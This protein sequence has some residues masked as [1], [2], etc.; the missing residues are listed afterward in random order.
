M[1]KKQEESKS[2]ADT[3]AAFG[4]FVYN[5][6]DGTV[7]GRGA[8]SWGR[9]GVFYLFYYAFLAGLFALSINLCMSLMDDDQPFYQTRLQ[10]PGVTIQ[11]KLPSNIELTS[12][13][14]YKKSD[15]KGYGKYVKHLDTFLEPYD[16]SQFGECGE[17]GYGY[18]EGKPCIF[19]KVNRI[20]GWEPYPFLNLKEDSDRVAKR[21]ENSK[22]PALVDVLKEEQY[23]SELMYIACYPV[24]KKQEE[25]VEKQE[26]KL[27]NMT[28][29][30]RGITIA[31]NFPFTGKNPTTGVAHDGTYAQPLVAVKLDVLKMG[32]E[33]SVGCKAYAMNILDDDRTNA[34]YI[35]FKVKIEE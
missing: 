34:G 12:D 3:A 32:E 28:Y 1:G 11:P 29:S 18:A 33:I 8:G 27:G 14:M 4:K 17:E 23:N 26:E 2:L 24:P 5:G 35:H 7:F 22:A 30:P 25:A 13:I 9:L 15:S 6:E 31:G 20:I 19:V 16:K 10:A 21:A